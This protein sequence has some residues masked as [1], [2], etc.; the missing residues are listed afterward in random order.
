ML[1]KII[2]NIEN[3][4][5]KSIKRLSQDIINHQTAQANGDYWFNEDTNLWELNPDVR[6][7]YITSPE[8][9]E[10]SILKR[11]K[12]LCGGTIPS[13]LTYQGDPRGYVVYFNSGE[14]SEKEKKMLFEAG[15]S[16]DWGGNYSILKN[17]Q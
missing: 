1:Q 16:R 7:R 10:K 15:F 14:L 8:E 4:P 6:A 2:Q 13:Y 12:D 9:K 11:L 5:I 17:N 3:T